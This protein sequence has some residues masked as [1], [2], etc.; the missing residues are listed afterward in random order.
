[1]GAFNFGDGQ[2]DR[3]CFETIKLSYCFFFLFGKA[4]HWDIRLEI[5][6]T[7]TIKRKYF[8]FSYQKFQPVDD[9]C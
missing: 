1:M 4:R 8:A 9:R 7:D 3:S 2:Y 6:D 5:L